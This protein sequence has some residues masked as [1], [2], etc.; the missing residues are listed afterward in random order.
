M[1]G[2]GF[3]G[4]LG[5]GSVL[6]DRGSVGIGQFVYRPQGVM[7]RPVSLGPRPVW[8]VGRKD[9]L[10]E[11]HTRL[12]DG[13]QAGPRIIA[14]YG[15]GGAGK[16]SVAVEYAHQQQSTAGVVWQFP[17]EDPTVLAAEFARLATQLGAS[18][19]LLGPSDPVAAVHAILAASPTAWL[20]VFDNVVDHE[21]V[22]VFLPP[23][24]NGRVLITTQSAPWPSSLGLEVPVLDS[25]VAAMFLAARTGDADANAALELAE[26]LGGLPLALEQAGAYVQASGGSLASY[27]VAFRRRRMD[28][29]ARGEPF[30]YSKTVATTWALAFERLKQLPVASGLLQ[31]LACCASEPVPLWL[32][33]QSQNAVDDLPG[34]DLTPALLPLLGDS[35]AA[36]DAI[37][38]LRRFS[39]V[40]LVGHGLVLVHR[41][42]QAVTLDQMTADVTEQWRQTAGA[43]I[44]AAIPA[45]TT[46]P[47]NWPLYAAL[48]PHA[49][50]VLACESD[51]MAQIAN[52]L[53][54]SG[55]YSAARDLQQQI[56]DAR[57]RLRGGDHPTTLDACSDLAYWTWHAG[58]I[59]AA[60][61]LFAGLLPVYERVL[62]P[63]HPETLNVRHNLAWAW[64]PWDPGG[65][66]DQYAALL[67]IKERVLGPEHPETLKTRHNLG[68]WTGKA[69]DP[70]GARDLLAALLPIRERILGPEHPN[71]LTTRDNLARFTGKAG[72]PAGARDLLAGLLPVE[73]R[74][75]GPEHPKTLQTRHDLARWTGKAGDPA[76]ACDQLATL[77]PIR[78]E[79]LGPE[80][81]KTLK[82]RHEI[83]RWTGEAGDPAGARDLLAT[84][85][86]V[87]ERVLGPEHPDALITR[88]N[89]A[90]WTGEAGDPAGA[91]DLLAALLPV[92]E[93]VFGP[94]HP[95]TV[96]TRRELAYWRAKA[97]TAP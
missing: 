39:L 65:A 77:L 32:L 57:E 72:D 11:L 48:L 82:T 29:L 85:L 2:P 83:A 47:E 10:I 75:L 61:D 12:T 50:A 73:E 45:D 38:T 27:L 74:V 92:E 14:L 44:A 70:A 53:G 66:R 42:V 1:A 23:A 3:A 69:G 91:G 78:E 13:N 19:G 40:T 81:P 34:P 89:L 31:L 37:A 43:M 79:I 25:A 84:L 41:L 28:L 95:G 56:V 5:P 16:T 86:P 7:G 59:A 22:Q 26:E 68:Y 71:T 17:A 15:L 51:G 55:S 93:Q 97:Q 6:A 64:D 58:D 96:R 33:L 35:L 94:E 88:R 87:E 90:R 8:L 46:Q 52:Y 63:E 24:G 20:L 18:G 60:R 30:G 80:H 4:E 49:R 54:N 9:L 62:G 67:P 76:A 36:G 21:S